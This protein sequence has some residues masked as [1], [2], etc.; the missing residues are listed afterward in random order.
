M[1]MNNL[2]N[3]KNDVGGGSWNINMKKYKEFR[4]LSIGLKVY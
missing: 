3:F 4:L 2:I 1:K